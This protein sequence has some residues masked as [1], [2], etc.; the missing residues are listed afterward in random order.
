MKRALFSFFFCALVGILLLPS[1]QHAASV[2]FHLTYSNFFPS[3]HIQS[4]LAE[5][6]TK[7]VERR[8]GGRVHIDYFPAGTL[9]RAQHIFDGVEQGISDIGMSALSYTRGRF[10]LMEALDLPM[11]YKN[12]VAAT[13]AANAVFARFAPREMDKV[14][15]MYFHA[16]GPGVLHTKTAPV[17]SMDDLRRLKIRAT[18]SSAK[19]LTALGATPVAMSMSDTYL[20]LQKG[21]VDGSV[22]PLETN[23]GWKM[24]EVVQHATPAAATSYTTTFF[25][26][27]RKGVWDE[28]P[29]DIQEIIREINVEWAEKHAR[30]WDSSDALGLELFQA[31]G[32]IVHTLSPEE[33]ARWDTAVQPLKA[34]YAQ[35]VAER[36]IDGHAVLACISDVLNTDEAFRVNNVQ[37]THSAHSTD[38]AAAASAAQGEHHAK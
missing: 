27:M 26:V 33:A 24:A 2:Q 18:G 15:P 16:H 1:P 8:T 28:L 29:Q 9:T 23:K 6:W 5:A 32:G 37:N 36:G 22:Y 38:S 13:H 12:G 25:A 19:V 11:G 10:P 4:Q 21:V 14:E 20:S 35:Q 7:E 30:A 17:T 31:K 3:S 34:Q